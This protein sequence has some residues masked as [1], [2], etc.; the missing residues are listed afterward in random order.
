V[1]TVLSVF[2][3]V[4]LI[5][6]RPLSPDV[7]ELGSLQ[8]H[9]KMPWGAMSSIANRA[10]GATLSV[11]EGATTQQQH[12]AAYGLVPRFAGRQAQQGPRLLL[13]LTQTG[14]WRARG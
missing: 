9:Y 13:L 7:F 10:T 4:Q 12:S 6:K 11:G 5:N 3:S 1:L 2:C 8:P 14:A